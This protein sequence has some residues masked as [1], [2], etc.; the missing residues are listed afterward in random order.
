MKKVI[1]TLAMLMIPIISFAQFN[2][3][4]KI[5]YNAATMKTDISDIKT[6]FMHGLQLGAFVR[7][8]GTWYIQPEVMYTQKGSII[9]LT[10]D[11]DYTIKNNTVDIPIIIG[12]KLIDA[13]Q[14]GMSFQVGP[15]ASILTDK[16]IQDVGD[17]LENAEYEDLQWGVQAGVGID[18]LMFTIDL[19]YE[20]GLNDILEIKEKDL[21]ENFSMKNQRIS[22][23]VGWKLLGL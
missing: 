2:I 19:R 14:L 1:L 15:V 8:G 18:F 3:G 6:D 23:T 11:R 9:T 10:D 7:L 20:A 21:N 13:P 16:G 4:P 22:L 12:Y 17:I 5:G